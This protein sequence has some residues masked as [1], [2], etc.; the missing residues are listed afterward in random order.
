MDNQ[1]LKCLDTIITIAPCNGTHILAKPKVFK[2]FIDPDFTNLRLGKPCVATKE[3]VIQVYEMV[4]GKV[5]WAQL[6]G[7]FDAVLDKLCLTQHQI[8]A[9]CENNFNWLCAK[10]TGTFFLTKKNWKAPATLNN[11]FVVLVFGYP[12]GLRIFACRFENDSRWYTDDPYC[13]VVP[14]LVD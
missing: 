7:F 11:L 10:D 13:F 9:F 6:F 4:K 2:S 1:Y 5:S 12:S 3:T 8:E 14:Q